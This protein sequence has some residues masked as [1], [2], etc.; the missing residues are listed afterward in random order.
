MT[1]RGEPRKATVDENGKPSAVL[2]DM[3]REE[4]ERIASIKHRAQPRPEAGG[5]IPVAPA[6]GKLAHRPLVKVEIAPNGTPV[7]RREGEAM[8]D[9]R[10]VLGSRVSDA[11][12]TMEYQAQR[13][14]V[15]RQRQAEREGKDEPVYSS[16]FAPGQISAAR[17]YASLVERTNGSG[18][19]CSA[20]ESQSGGSGN[21]CREEAILGDLERLRNL[22]RRIGDGIAKSPQR[23]SR[24]TVSGMKRQAIRVRY[25]VDRVAL[26]GWT[27]ADVLKRS[28]W[29]DTG[30]NKKALIKALSSALDR[31]QGYDL[32]HPQ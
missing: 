30:P 28:G 13:S 25:L 12:D 14:F 11:W 10:Y 2:V 23:P 9:G 5:N 6:R 16:P 15:R 20:L 7:Y 17:D 31:M 32:A 18:V 21:G 8:E 3:K 4:R 26:D 27:L 22:H 19:K 1:S 24:A 29:A